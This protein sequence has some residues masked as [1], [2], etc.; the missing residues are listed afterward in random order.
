MVMD[1]AIVYG[2]KTGEGVG[3]ERLSPW[4]TTTPIEG[5]VAL[6]LGGGGREDT[7]YQSVDEKSIDILKQSVKLALDYSTKWNEINLN[8]GCPS[9]KAVKRSFGSSLMRMSSGEHTRRAVSE[10]VRIAGARTPITVKCRLGVS[11]GGGGPDSD[12]RLGYDAL[13][14]FVRGVRDGGVRKVILHSRVCMMS[15]LSTGENRN[16]PPLMYD[17]VSRVKRDFGDIEIVLNGGVRSLEEGEGLLGRRNGVDFSEKFN[18]GKDSIWGE[19]DSSPPLVDG[20]MIGRWAY[21]DPCGL[22]DADSRFYGKSDRNPT[23][24]E[25]LTEYVSKAS[26]AGKKKKNERSDRGRENGT[27]RSEATIFCTLIASLLVC[28]LS[29]TVIALVA[30]SLHQQQVLRRCRRCNPGERAD[31]NTSD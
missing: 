10:C 28:S 15:G 18:D 5:P 31:I 8:M 20:V 19:M 1:T 4:L 23:L 13:T 25:I 16:V 24:R 3:N 6:Q 26:E 7:T 29:M 2:M 12:S 9:S 14:S 30:N 11:C 22:W 17:V 21:N 27:R